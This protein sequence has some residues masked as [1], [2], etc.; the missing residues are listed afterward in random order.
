MRRLRKTMIDYLVIAVSPAMIIAMIGSLVFFLLEVFYRGQHDVRLHVIFGLFVMAAVLIGRIA[1]ED[2][3]ERAGLFAA[4]LAIVTFLALCRFVKFQGGAS[5]YSGMINLMLI[6][7]IWW[8]AHKLTWDCTLID[9]G[10]LDSGEG[11]LES[12]GLEKPTQTD[13]ER[14]AEPPE[15]TTSPDEPGPSWWQRYVEHQR[16]PH[17]PGV[18]VVYFSLAALPLFGVGQK[19]VPEDDRQYAFNLLFVYVASGLGL[20]LST[21]FLGLR[22]YLRQRRVEMPAAMANLW[23]LIGGVLIVVL[24]LTVDFLPRPSAEYSITQLPF[25][26]GSPSRKPSRVAVGRDGVE[27]EDRESS[28]F[29]ADA[30]RE[31]QGEPQQDRDGKPSEG[32]P[33]DDSDRDGG[34][35]QGDPQQGRSDQNDP[36][37]DESDQTPSERPEESENPP[38]E[39]GSQRD[40]DPEQGNSGSETPPEKLEIR[41]AEQPSSPRPN[42][43]GGSLA[44][45]KTAARWLFWAAAAVL[46]LYWLWRS[47]E[48]VLATLREFLQ[49]W[50]EFWQRLFGGK[51]IGEQAAD[52]TEEVAKPPPRPFADF[53]DPFAS[54]TAARFSPDELVRYT[55]EA[56]EAW[57]REHDCPREVDQTPHELARRVGER[58]EELVVPVRRLA[59]LYCRVAYAPGT[60]PRETTGSL[61]PIWASL[62]RAA[63]VVN[64]IPE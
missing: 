43:L 19:F 7:L 42:P 55:F 59:D 63:T 61:E 31:S 34:D 54:G 26:I 36:Q 58:A 39:N 50:R 1:I 20:L 4:P 30:R 5:D 48:Q 28:T 16:R 33:E 37:K 22:R 12:A 57:A 11:L 52:A 13:D 14:P 23:L 49:G 53:T 51:R 9:E 8:C 64:V 60:L 3:K 29:E 62:R 18:W 47:R 10:E 17:A 2:G 41:H 56:L 6:A 24:L 38:E 32:R 46:G 44:W 35:R 15:G 25:T 21:S 27:D 45:L 40:D